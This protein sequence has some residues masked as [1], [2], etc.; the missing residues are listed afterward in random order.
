[1]GIGIVFKSVMLILGVW[2]FRSKFFEPYFKVVMQ[3]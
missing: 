3:S 2:L 1:M